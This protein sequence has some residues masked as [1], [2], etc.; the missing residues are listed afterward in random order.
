MARCAAV[1][2]V[3]AA[4]PAA[5]LV[6]QQRPD[7]GSIHVLAA[8]RQD[9]ARLTPN[10]RVSGQTVAGPFLAVAVSI[11][12]PAGGGDWVAVHVTGSGIAGD[13][14]ARGLRAETDVR[15]DSAYVDVERAQGGG[16]I[17]VHE[18]RQFIILWRDQISGPP[19][20]TP[21]GAL[22]LL[23]A[24]DRTGTVGPLVLHVGEL[25][26]AVRLAGAARRRP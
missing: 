24:L 4:V 7:S 6:A 20:L 11:R 10:W 8:V 5:S 14:H 9:S 17:G 12:P 21:V 16:I 19:Q 22:G 1:L 23:F 18:G 3:L 2:A 26:A 13:G 15:A 25:T